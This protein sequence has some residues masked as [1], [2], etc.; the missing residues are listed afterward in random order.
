MKKEKDRMKDIP[1][2]VAIRLFGNN[3][4]IS[5]YILKT[6]SLSTDP[7]NMEEKTKSRK[8]D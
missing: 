5:K 3:D 4:N 1:V 6:G 2:D 8:K 7:S